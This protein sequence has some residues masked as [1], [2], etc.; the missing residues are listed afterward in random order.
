VAEEEILRWIANDGFAIVVA[1][2]LLHR[3]EKKLDT[4]ILKLS[5]A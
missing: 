1:V 5:E 4:I 2:Y 3:I